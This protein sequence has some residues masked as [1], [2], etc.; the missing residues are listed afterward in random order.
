MTRVLTTLCDLL[1]LLFVGAISAVAFESI[2]AAF[3]CVAVAGAY[4]VITYT[5]GFMRAKKKFQRGPE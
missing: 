5:D 1:F 4:S 3:G 2:W